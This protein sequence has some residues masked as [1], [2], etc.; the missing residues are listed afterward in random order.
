MPEIL[1]R[2]SIDASPET[3]HE[4]ITT[5]D[6]VG[7]WWTGRPA[8]GDAAIGGRLAFYFGDSERPAA[9]MEVLEDRPEKVV[10][11]CVEGPDSWV[12]TSVTFS[13][14]TSG[15]AQTTLLFEHSGWR[16]TSEFMAGCSTNWGAYLTSLKSG[17]EGAGF[18]AYPHGE[19]SRWG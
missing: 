18:A 7:Q 17:A 12:G 16:E 19:I 15:A 5:T 14:A 6:G 1:H 4:L 2:I 10:W 13:L 8:T 3:V 9:V 11:K